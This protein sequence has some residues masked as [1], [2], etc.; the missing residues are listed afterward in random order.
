M[1]RSIMAS[2]QDCEDV[3]ISIAV[4]PQ[5]GGKSILFT[6]KP[7]GQVVG[8]RLARNQGSPRQSSLKCSSTSW[9][10]HPRQ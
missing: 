9:S 10:Q 7:S 8:H 4:N 2:V 1:A 5:N 3:T 6:C